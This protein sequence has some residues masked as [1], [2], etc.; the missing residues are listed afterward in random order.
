M[1]RLSF[2]FGALLLLAAC[3]TDIDQDDYLRTCTAASECRTIFQGSRCDCSCDYGAINAADY[4]KY[5]SDSEG[6]CDA[7]C[8]PCQDAVVSCTDGQCVIA[9]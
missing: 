4:D 5:L 6:E 3:S 9:P 2:A 7:L 1:K 8:A